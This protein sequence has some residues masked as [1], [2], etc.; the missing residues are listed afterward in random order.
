MGLEDLFG[1]QVNGTLENSK[2]FYLMERVNFIMM[3]AIFMKEIL[4]GP[5]V[6]VT[7]Y[8]KKLMDLFMKDNLR[9][10]LFMVQGNIK[11]S[12][13]KNLKVFFKIRR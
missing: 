12:M 6:M 3:M 4:W 9:K 7:E 5:N 13:V 11:Q 1:V 10:I 8:L 2:I